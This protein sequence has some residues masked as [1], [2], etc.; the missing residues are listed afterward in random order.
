[1]PGALA[2]ATLRALRLLVRKELVT[3]GRRVH[4]TLSLLVVVA[5]VA[6]A[7]SYMVSGPAAPL[8]SP[9]DAGLTIAA[10][11]LVTLFLTSY[12]AGFLL[13]IREAE[14]GTLD[15]LRAAPV[16]PE[17]VYAA[18]TLASYAVVLG[19]AT[20]YTLLTAFLS[21]WYAMLN[22]YYA[23]Y[24]VFLALFFS[25]ATTLT[26]IMVSFSEESRSLLAVVVLAGVAVPYMTSYSLPLA[27]TV[28]GAAVDLAGIASSTLGFTILSALQS[29]PL[30]EI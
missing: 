18:K 27:F 17:I 10:G 25:S 16:A 12:S 20:V 9:E 28:Q 7:V 13:V 8:R 29:R 24:T 4:E 14:K 23:A 1:M 2:A 21:S 26:S 11:L 19:L 5:V 22:P 3:L 6:V 15:G 30:T